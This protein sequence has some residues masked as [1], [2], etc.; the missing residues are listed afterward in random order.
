MV[1]IPPNDREYNDLSSTGR[2]VVNR[3]KEIIGTGVS[4]WNAYHAT[5]DGPA[6]L[7]GI[8]LQNHELIGAVFTNADLRGANLSNANLS[9]SNFSGADLRGAKLVGAYLYG[10]NLRDANLLE[11]L[12]TEACLQKADLRDTNFLDAKL[13]KANIR[14]ASLEGAFLFRA[15]LAGADLD[16]SHG[17]RLDSTHIAGA[18]LPVSTPDDWS[19]LRR[20]YTGSAMAVNLL[21]SALF[22]I[23]LFFRAAIWTVVN[24]LQIASV[25]TLH[26]IGASPCLAASCIRRP[27]WEVVLGVGESP[28]LL[29]A[30][31]C[32]LVYNG[33]RIFLTVRISPLR[34]EEERSGFSPRFWPMHPAP[35][36]GVD[37]IQNGGWP[38]KAAVFLHRFFQSYRWMTWLHHVMQLLVWVALLMLAWH[39]WRWLMLAVYLPSN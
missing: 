7:A 12:L 37:P 23:P 11:A 18:R 16:E 4:A 17:V 24:R 21:L 15:D 28:L 29:A 2:A 33:L 22:L 1:R 8:E 31:V 30:S 36:D 38:S 20:N 35:Y 25:G 19:V 3:H 14:S 5:L 10:A 39:V 27:V 6:K 34:D 32:L 26:E 13:M 9:G